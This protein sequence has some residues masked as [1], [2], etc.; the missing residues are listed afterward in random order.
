MVFALL[1]V[2]LFIGLNVLRNKKPAEPVGAPTPAQRAAVPAAPPVSPVA[3]APTPSA[4]N[5]ATP[6][7]AAAAEQTTVVENELY[8][9]VFTNRGAQVKSW[10]LKKYKDDAGKPLDLVQTKA[11]QLAGLPLSV[12]TYDPTLRKQ[13]D[14][15]LF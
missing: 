8:R 6:A 7:V 12:F 14:Q 2:V 11:S 10:I 9:I 15:A 4:A 3:P 1:F 13:L 5:A